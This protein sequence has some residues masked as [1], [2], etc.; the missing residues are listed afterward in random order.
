MVFFT[1]ICK[2]TVEDKRAEKA[3]GRLLAIRRASDIEDWCSADIRRCHDIASGGPTTD[4][5]LNELEEL[6]EHIG[7]CC[8]RRLDNG[9]TE[10]GCGL[11]YWAE[12]PEKYCH[13]CKGLIKYT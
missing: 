2:D 8:S 9:F 6:Q 4:W 1:E 13:K 7:E 10:S 3:E 12:E 5:L 11:R